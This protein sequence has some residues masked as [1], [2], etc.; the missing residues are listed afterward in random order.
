[1]TAQIGVRAGLSPRGDDALITREGKGRDDGPGRLR[2]IV[3][4]VVDYSEECGHSVWRKNVGAVLLNY[5]TQIASGQAPRLAAGPSDQH[6][7][8]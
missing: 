7:T 4:I 1:M 6:G 8:A 2:G 5:P 3:G